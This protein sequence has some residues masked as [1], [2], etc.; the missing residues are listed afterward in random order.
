MTDGMLAIIKFMLKCNLAHIIPKRWNESQTIYKNSPI[1]LKC[2]CVLCVFSRCIC[3]CCCCCF[4]SGPWILSS[5]E[6]L[7]AV[8]FFLSSSSNFC[9]RA[10][11]WIW[12]FFQNRCSILLLG[13]VSEPIWTTFIICLLSLCLPPPFP[14]FL[15]FFSLSSL[16]SSIHTFYLLQNQWNFCC[17]FT[18]KPL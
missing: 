2:F 10:Y 13:T 9:V 7:C 16:L 18:L 3:C 14:P 12:F 6:I 4:C 1:T 17:N 15:S 8:R 5:K 11:S